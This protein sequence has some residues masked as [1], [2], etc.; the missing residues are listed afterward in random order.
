MDPKD[1]AVNGNGSQDT[2]STAPATVETQAQGA[3]TIPGAVDT[4]ANQS[5]VIDDSDFDDLDAANPVTGTDA[6]QGD[7]DDNSVQSEGTDNNADPNNG[8][9]TNNGDATDAN[10]RTKDARLEQ[11]D[12][13]IAE[14]RQQYAT[15][16]NGDVRGRVAERDFLQ[17]QI[18]RSTLQGAQLE[19]EQRLLDMVNPDTGD[20]Y[21]PEDAGSI[22]RNAVLQV[23]RQQV[24]Q[25]SYE[26][27]IERNQHII[28]GEVNQALRE[29]S[30]FDDKSPQYDENAANLAGKHLMDAYIT[31]PVVGRD[32]RQLT[33]QDGQPLIRVVGIKTS[34]YQIMKDVA[35]GVARYT[36]SAQAK[37]T[38][39]MARQASGADIPLNGNTTATRK[40]PGAD[41]DEA[42]DDV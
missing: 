11:L 5:P 25:R 23:E 36:S 32:G 1:T 24:G 34:P 35:E 20:Y 3:N 7:T 18:D 15:Q 9:G 12:R 6:T 8:D 37:A 40:D 19:I 27:G 42:W 13:E 10:P 28:S 33:G 38:T 29:F 30:I 16:P 21:S 39:D 14:L 41:F 26:L 31:E 17:Q 22:A 4:S 2:T